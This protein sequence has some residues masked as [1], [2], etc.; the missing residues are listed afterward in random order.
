MQGCRTQAQSG[1]EPASTDA[2]PPEPP[3]RISD[4]RRSIPAWVKLQ[5]ILNQGA[6]CKMTG[7][8]FVDARAIRFDHRPALWE[9]KFDPGT[10]DFV[11]PQNDPAFIEAV[12]S[13]EHDRRTFGAGGEKRIA[14]AGSDLHRKAKV[15][16]L[17]R[18]HEDFRRRVVIR[19][20]KNIESLTGRSKRKI[21]SRPFPKRK[22]PLPN[23]R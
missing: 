6:R 12:E 13:K 4:H 2:N 1:T 21:R 7:H 23:A 9:R 22:C 16:R 5:V 15:A 10:G 3:F 18:E 20:P 17:S 19:E 11:P 14:A 8:V